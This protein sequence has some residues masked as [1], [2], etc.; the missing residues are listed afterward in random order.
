[1][2]Q[3]KLGLET[4]FLIINSFSRA[5]IQ[6]KKMP[7]LARSM[8]N[9]GK[10]VK[11]WQAWVSV[12]ETVLS[13]TCTL[14]PI[15]KHKTPNPKNIRKCLFDF[16]VFDHIPFDPVS[17]LEPAGLQVPKRRP[18]GQSNG[19]CCKWCATNGLDEPDHHR[20]PGGRRRADLA[21]STLRCICPLSA[22][23]VVPD[24]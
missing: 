15:P 5:V 10:L 19:L 1:M 12:G 3:P 22:F 7:V 20:H 16:S 6:Q 24:R 8:K 13:G 4:F 2:G 17:E 21:C 18:V 14:S 11:K 9:T 23:A